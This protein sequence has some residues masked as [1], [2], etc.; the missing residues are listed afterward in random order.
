MT[1]AEA[2]GRTIDEAVER[3][4]AQ[5][6]VA[7]GEVDV[8]I[9]QEPKAALLGFGGREARVRLTLRPSAAEILGSVAAE[10]VRL[11][12]FSASVRVEETAD[13]LTATLQ[14]GD[15]A[16]LV[17][18]DGRVLDA[19]ELIAGLHVQRRLGRKASVSVDAMGYRARRE[20][21]VREAAL[22]AAER[23]V[24]EGTAVAL[25]PMSARDRRTAHLALKNDARVTTSSRGEDDARQ[26]VV[27]LRTR[28][29]SSPTQ[30]SGSKPVP[31]E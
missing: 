26:V 22:Q 3:A 24:R 9:L 1:S 17:G 18:R 16:G 4:L 6:G 20:Q 13:G 19:L 12:G 30:D 21:A 5:L 31:E 27:L 14:G 8:E 23:V 2:S 10:T 25:G 15:L 7:R 29:E 11:M 28:D